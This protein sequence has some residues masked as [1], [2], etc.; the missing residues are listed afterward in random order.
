VGGEVLQLETC[1]IDNM[2]TI[3]KI[4]NKFFIGI[5]LYL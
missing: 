1:P 4:K 2:G 5:V 3:A